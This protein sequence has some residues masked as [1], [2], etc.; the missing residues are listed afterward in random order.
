M[1]RTWGGGERRVLLEVGRNH[2]LE[3][4]GEDE[5]V[6]DPCLELGDDGVAGVGRTAATEE[7]DA[8]QPGREVEVGEG[9]LVA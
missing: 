5:P 8:R 7:G 6:A 2:G 9:D 1:L 3:F 4:L